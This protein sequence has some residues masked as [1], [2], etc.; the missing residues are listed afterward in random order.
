M[1]TCRIIYNPMSG[2]K[3]FEKALPIVTKRLEALGFTCNI[4]KTAYAKHAIELVKNAAYDRVNLVVVSGGDGTMNEIINGIAD[5]DNPPVIGYIPSGTSCD[6]AKS[7]GIPKNIEKAL[8]IIEQNYHVKMDVLKS[9]H[10]YFNY[11]SAIGNYVDISYITESALKRRIGYL[12]YIITGVKEFFTIPMI[13]TKIETPTR[14]FEGY[15]SLIMAVNSK[16]VASFNMVRKPILDDG[17]LDIILYPYI[18]LL[19]NILYL[20]TFVLNLPVPLIKKLKTNKIKI[21]TDHPKRWNVD[22]EAANAGNQFIEVVPKKLPI[23][24]NP[25]K[26]KYFKHQSE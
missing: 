16:R 3:L 22:G 13:K 24:I 25:K 14:S 5:I 15:Y 12:A 26:A 9:S 1:K 18:P 10:G 4:D 20:L 19:N 21:L 11:V 6:L 7:L 2:K 17:K 23:I 8:N